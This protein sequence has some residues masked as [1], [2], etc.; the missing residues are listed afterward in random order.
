MTWHVYLVCLTVTCEIRTIR[1]SHKQNI[2]VLVCQVAIACEKHDH[3]ARHTSI[4]DALS[5]SEKGASCFV[6]KP[7]PINTAF[8]FTGQPSYQ[9][10]WASF[11]K[12]LFYNV[13]PIF[14]ILIHPWANVCIHIYTDVIACTFLS[15]SELYFP[16]LSMWWYHKLMFVYAAVFVFV[17]IISGRWSN[18]Y[19]PSRAN[20]PIRE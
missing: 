1:S 12:I 5:S 6:S 14:C 8:I 15:C 13:I 20:R 19:S 9:T 17:T 11:L 7:I 2:S 18:Q 4:W 3:C 16:H 10:G